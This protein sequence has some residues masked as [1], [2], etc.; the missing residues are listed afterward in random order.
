MAS[1][2]G[3]ESFVYIAKLA[4]QA[5]RYNEMVVA[6]K[7]AANLGVELTVEERNLLFFGYKNVVGSRRSAWRILS[8]IEQKEES[9][10]NELHVKRI[11]EYRPNVEAELSTI[12]FDIIT[13]IDEHLVPPSLGAESTVFWC[14][15]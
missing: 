14:K 11:R 8:S 15:M 5:E 4:K 3:R 9:E 10:G 13:L 2:K 12:C 1:S 6:M 7:K